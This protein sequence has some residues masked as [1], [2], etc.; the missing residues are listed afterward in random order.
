VPP[1]YSIRINRAPVLT[2]WAAVVA[3]RLGA[4]RDA[5]LT[6]GQAV[7]GMTAHSKG[8]RLGIYAPSADRRDEPPVPKPAGAT[9][10][11]QLVLLGRHVPVAE[12]RDGPRAIAKGEIVKPERVEKYLASKFGE[13]LEAARQ[14]LERLAE[15]VPVDKLNERAFPL[16][17][18]FRPDVPEDEKGWGAKGVL[19]LAKIDALAKG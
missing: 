16:Y 18:V 7:A 10:V 14:R 19:D 8:V 5:A 9:S 2:L 12:T 6:F 13:H 3:E 15:S 17:L 1:S 11:R 4:R